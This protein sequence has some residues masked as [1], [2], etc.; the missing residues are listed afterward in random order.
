MRAIRKLLGRGSQLSAKPVN[1]LVQ[2]GVNTTSVT[3]DNNRILNKLNEPIQ[4]TLA[5]RQEL[6]PD[7]YVYR[8][9]LPEE[10]PLGHLTCQYLQF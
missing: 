6:S 3:V 1:P 9:A 5:N 7:T 10:R 2:Q 4:I 8:F